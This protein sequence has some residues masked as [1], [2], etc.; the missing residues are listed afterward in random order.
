[1]S[2]TRK[3]ETLV[4]AEAVA[5]DLADKLITFMETGVPPEGAFTADVFCDFHAAVAPAGAGHRGRHGTAKGG[6]PGPLD[7]S[8]F[9]VRHNGNGLRSR[10]GR[11]VGR[12]R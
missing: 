8:A 2:H 11:A 12:L 1:M 5:R 6:P 3:D 7:R 9:Q 10:G 4:Q